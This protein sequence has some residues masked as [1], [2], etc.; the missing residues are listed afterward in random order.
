[1]DRLRNK[2][3]SRRAFSSSKASTGIMRLRNKRRLVLLIRYN[4]FF[5]LDGDKA[6]GQKQILRNGARFS[7]IVGTNILHAAFT[8]ILIR[9]PYI[10]LTKASLPC[11]GNGNN[12]SRIHI[13]PVN[14]QLL[15]L[16][17]CLNGWSH[18]YL[19]L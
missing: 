19:P 9:S 1:M 13:P 12:T 3:L 5:R 14:V 7:C 17:G 18:Q 16:L 2:S 8:K 11:L 10:A 6:R 15:G 4:S